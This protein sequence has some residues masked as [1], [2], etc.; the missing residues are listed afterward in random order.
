MGKKRARDVSDEQIVAAYR[1]LRSQYKVAKELGIGATTVARVLYSRGVELTGLAEF[2]K[3]ITR[4]K[5]QES[6][7]RRQYEAGATYDQLRELFG[8]CSDYALKG[9][10]QRAG[11]VLRE[12]PAKRLQDGELEKIKSLHESG[13]GQMAISVQI[14]RSQSFVSRVM[15]NHNIKPHDARHENHPMWKGGRTIDSHGYARLWVPPADPLKCMA[16]SDGYVLEHRYV[17]AKHLGRPL[18]RY[19]TIHHINGKRDDNRLENLQLRHGKHGKG[20]CLRC[21]CCGSTD[22]EKVELD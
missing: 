2:R 20:V 9:A 5:G 22:I 11:G 14:G 3:N 8:E 17:M 1:R 16:L 18:E 15:R 13:L 19:E 7:I 12:N 21:R 10:I 6:D 4:F